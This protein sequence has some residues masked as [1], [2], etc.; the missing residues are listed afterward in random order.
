MLGIDIPC[1]H[2]FSLGATFPILNL[3]SIKL[4]NK[5]PA[6]QIH[7]NIIQPEDENDDN[8]SLEEQ[9]KKYAINVIK[10][11]THNKQ[12]DKITEFVNEKYQPS[13]AFVNNRGE[14]MLHLICD[15]IRRFENN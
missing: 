3:P 10:R 13:V 4:E 15:G 8:L 9:E 12:I 14:E 2:R 5:W 11:F 7:Y 1:C 6:L